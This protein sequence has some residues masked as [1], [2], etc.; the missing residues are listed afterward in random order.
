MSNVSSSNGDTVNII[1]INSD[2]IKQLTLFE[3]RG[4]REHPG[5]KPVRAEY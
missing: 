3:E 4:K 1:K 5:K 2:Q